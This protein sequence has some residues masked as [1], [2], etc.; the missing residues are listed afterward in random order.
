MTPEEPSKIPEIKDI[1]ESTVEMAAT[2]P[3][4]YRIGRPS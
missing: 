2:P 4:T 3:M 1:N